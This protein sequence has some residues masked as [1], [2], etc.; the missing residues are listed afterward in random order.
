MLNQEGVAIWKQVAETLASE[1]EQGLYATNDRLPTAKELASRFSVNRHTVLKAL[2][3][4]RSEGIVREERR[5]GTHILV[6]PIEFRIGARQWFDQNLLGNNA[7]PVRTVLSVDVVR[8]DQKLAE[9]LDLDVG[10]NVV[11]V[12]HL[13][14]SETMAINLVQT[15]F[16]EQR[17]PGIAEAFLAFGNNPSS[18]LSFSTVLSSVGVADF[19]RKFVRIRCRPSNREE[20]TAL[21]LVPGEYVQVTHVTSVDGNDVPVFYG[22]ASYP[23][24]RVDL[25][26]DL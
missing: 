15:Y 22:E 4:L 13:G 12:K 20:E 19:R 18:R 17:L 5:R 1:I 9:V 11:R 23:A 10:A 24:R 8:A 6:N 14:A 2:A 25:V 21:Q 3:H 16:P 26:I 7:L